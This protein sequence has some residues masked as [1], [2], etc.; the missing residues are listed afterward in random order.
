[1][2]KLLLDGL[3]EYEKP[4]DSDDDNVSDYLLLEAST[5]YKVH[6]TG[7]CDKSSFDEHSRFAAPINDSDLEEVIK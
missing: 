1:M 6:I 2:D 4:F 5:L 7:D 3:L